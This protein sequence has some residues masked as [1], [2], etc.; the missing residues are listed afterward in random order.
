[1][2][3]VSRGVPRHL[4]AD[5]DALEQHRY[6][7]ARGRAISLVSSGAPAPGVEV[8]IVDP[9]TSSE[10]AEDEVGE[11]WLRGASVASGYHNRPAETIERFHAHT[12]DGEHPYLRTG[13][14]GLLHGDELYVTGRLKDLLIINGR[15]LYP[16]DIE[17]F[18][19]D[20]HPAVAGS[21]GSVISVDVDD[22]ERLVLIQAIK[23][24][25]LGDMSCVELAAA[26]KGAVARG[27]EIPAPN[28]VFVNRAGIHL[29]TSGKVQRASM[30]TA[31]LKGE[32][33]DVLH[34]E[35]LR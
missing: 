12:S 1:M 33:T 28:V 32:L 5:S 10:L 30:R 6:T 27:F 17:E 24:E 11:I 21:R 19:Q 35:Q 14:L 22:A 26:V 9:E 23:S 3:T 31:F 20:V 18:V 15:N 34:Q 16:Q 8:R 29:T 13:D 2:A 4:D 7:P 25:L